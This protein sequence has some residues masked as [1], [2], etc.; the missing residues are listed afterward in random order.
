M[1]VD[2]K[3][4]AIATAQIVN[5][6]CTNQ[7]QLHTKISLVRQFVDNCLFLI[8]N[9]CLSPLHSGVWIMEVEKKTLKFH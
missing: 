4:R 5:Y 9:R 6:N 7:H 1:T 3:L 2:G 8:Q